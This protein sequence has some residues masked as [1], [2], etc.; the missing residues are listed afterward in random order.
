MY[1]LLRD[2]TTETL[3]AFTSLI[4]ANVRAELAK[5]ND[6]LCHDT[7]A[8][9]LAGPEGKAISHHIPVASVPDL[10]NYHN[11]RTYIVDRA[12]TQ[13]DPAIHQVVILGAGMDSRCYRIKELADCHVFEVDDCQVLMERKEKVLKDLDLPLLA[14]K[15]D[16]IMSDVGTMTWRDKLVACGFD[17]TQ[18][19]LW[20]LEG[21]LMYLT[22]EVNY[23][24]IAAIDELSAVHS[25]MWCD[26]VW[27]E[28]IKPTDN[29][30]I[31]LTDAIYFGVDHSLMNT[32]SWH[33]RVL[34]ARN[35]TNKYGGA[36]WDELRDAPLMAP[37]AEP[38]YG[39]FVFM[40][41]L[42]QHE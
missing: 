37:N 40:V 19:T 14:K 5:R 36:M 13:R 24:L 26:M 34:L 31:S 22:P 21:L 30:S 35:T 41:L 16:I 23:S 39:P 8:E 10:L 3:P 11:Y 15:R 20:L 28:S 12:F 42:K 6:S 7:L 9:A 38:V 17:R 18:P 29:V 27:M 2:L 25:Q 4:T 33:Q 1:P 32:L